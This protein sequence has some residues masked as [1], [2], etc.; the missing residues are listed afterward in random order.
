MDMGL[1]KLQELV[2]DKEAWHAAVHGVTKSRTWL[3]DWTEGLEHCETELLKWT[4]FVIDSGS[5]RSLQLGDFNRWNS[6]KSGIF[7]SF[8]SRDD[9][10]GF[11]ES[12]SVIT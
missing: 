5:L 11:I 8:I 1:S 4:I 12:D 7:H 9:L 3:S 6:N 10:L 2:M